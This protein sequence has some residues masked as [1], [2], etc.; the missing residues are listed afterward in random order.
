MKKNKKA[1]IIG[2]IA[3]IAILLGLLVL[4]VGLGYMIISGRL[5]GLIEQIKDIFSLGFGG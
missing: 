4:T 3:V 1:F 5:S 2:T